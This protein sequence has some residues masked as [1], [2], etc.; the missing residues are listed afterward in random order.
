MAALL[1][2]TNGNG[3]LSHP[4]SS[5]SHAFLWVADLLYNLDQQGKRGV[6]LEVRLTGKPDKKVVVNIM[7]QL[8]QDGF[9]KRRHLIDFRSFHGK[10]E[11]HYAGGT[12]ENVVKLVTSLTEADYRRKDGVPT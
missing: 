8:T 3:F 12:G 10:V 4:T 9:E 5:G 11:V 2:T 1:V 6:V 7:E